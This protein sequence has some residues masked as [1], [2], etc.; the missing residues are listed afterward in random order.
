MHDSKTV[1][2]AL[3]LKPGDAVLDLGC[4]PGDY[5][6]AAAPIVGTSGRVT[7]MDKWEYFIDQIQ[8]AAAS[9]NLGNLSAV[10][11]DITGPLPVEDRSIDRCLLSTVLHIFQLPVVE[12]TLFRE[13]RRILKPAGRLAVIECKKEEQPFGPP[14]HLR[15]SPE[16]LEASLGPLGFEKIGYLDLGYTYLIQFVCA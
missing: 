5:A 2:A 11:G 7:A 8:E 16:E 4:G 13:V 12:K 9:R 14:L 3:A 1:F 15:I 6:L 10:V